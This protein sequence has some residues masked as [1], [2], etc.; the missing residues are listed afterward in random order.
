MMPEPDVF[1]GAGELLDALRDGQ[2]TSVEL[3]EAFLDQIARHEWVNAIVTI[4]ADNALALAAEADRV[5]SAG[6][7]LGP[8][9]GLPMTIKDDCEVAGMLSTFGSVANRDHVPERDAEAVRRL[10][11]GRRHRL[12]PQQSARSTP[13]TVR[14]TMT[15]TAPRSTPGTP[16]GRPGGRRAARRQG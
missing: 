10:R 2:T 14:R 4:D 15:C 1:A 6:R 3:L 13:P 8:L 12:R 9:H 11:R 7:T 16:N 5:R